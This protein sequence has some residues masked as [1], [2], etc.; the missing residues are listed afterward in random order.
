MNKT[1]IVLVMKV[2]KKRNFNDITFRIKGTSSNRKQHI[3]S[4]IWQAMKTCHNIL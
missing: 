4:L 1:E 3:T 2:T